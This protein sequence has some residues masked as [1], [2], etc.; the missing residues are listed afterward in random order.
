MAQL[1]KD[2]EW[3]S[4][5]REEGNVIRLRVRRL[6]RLGL[7]RVVDAR[8]DVEEEMRSHIEMRVEQLVSE[9]WK[10]E[11]A[12][13]EAERR[14]ASSEQARRALEASAVRRESRL[15]LRDRL[16]SLVHDVGYVIRTLRR[17]PGFTLT[18]VVTLALG[19]GANA[20]LFALLDRM[21]LQNPT[22][23]R[24]PNEVRR[25][26]RPSGGAPSMVYSFP[27]LRDIAEALPP[28]TAYTGYRTELGVPFNS[29]GD[30][31]SGVL[32]SG[33]L[34]YVVGDYFGTLGVAM[35]RGRP[36][37]A[38]E[39]QATGFAP[40]T[41]ISSRFATSRYGSPDGALGK[42]LDIARRQHTIIGVAAGGIAPCPAGEPSTTHAHSSWRCARGR[43]A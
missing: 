7:H 25:V 37:A 41:V 17:S 23:V 26:H 11:D 10:Q 1:R 4:H 18:V 15:R 24:E 16:D 22:G 21:F 9:G 3:H 43:C 12:R 40:V 29:D 14:F 27:G 8:R 34:T 35:A 5:G 6:F 32:A 38:D 20:A 39:W 42:P 36:F 13:A 31:A 30:E 2:G 19:L 33:V 28:G